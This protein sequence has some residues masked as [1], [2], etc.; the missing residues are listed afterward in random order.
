M[1][2][3]VPAKFQKEL[4]LHGVL[5]YLKAVWGWGTLIFIA[6]VASLSQ[7]Y[8]MVAKKE[9][10]NYVLGSIIKIVFRILLGDG[11]ILPCIDQIPRHYS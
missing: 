8:N 10:N 9:K 11:L 1:V 7:Q 3:S 4:T 6:H 2:L 5:V